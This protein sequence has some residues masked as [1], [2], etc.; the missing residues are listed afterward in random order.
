MKYEASWMHGSCVR[1]ENPENLESHNTYGWG[2]DAAF[3]SSSRFLQVYGS[4][5]HAAVPSTLSIGE[6]EQTSLLSVEILFRATYC[7]LTQVDVYDGS[8]LI[9]TFRRG[10]TGDWRFKKDGDERDAPNYNTYA[11]SRPHRV[12]CGIGVSFRVES[13]DIHLAP[14]KRGEARLSVAAVGA[15]F[16]VGNPSL[17]DRVR[18]LIIERLVP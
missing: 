8:R 9:E 12:F 15:N 14:Y 10:L 1:V 17:T 11:L 5:F 4:W 2:T 16:R 3:R 7:T 6:L 18:S 13:D